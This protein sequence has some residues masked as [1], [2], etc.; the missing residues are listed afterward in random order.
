MARRTAVAQSVILGAD[1]DLSTRAMQ[2]LRASRRWA[3]PSRLHVVDV[4]QP[5]THDTDGTRQLREA[6]TVSIWDAAVC[7]FA[8]SARMVISSAETRR[9]P[10]LLAS[11]GEVDAG[12]V[13]AGSLRT[14]KLFDHRACPSARSRA[15]QATLAGRR[16]RPANRGGLTDVSHGRISAKR[17]PP[18]RRVGLPRR[19]PSPLPGAVTWLRPFV[20]LTCLAVRPE[21]PKAADGGSAPYGDGGGEGGEGGRGTRSRPSSMRAIA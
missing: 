21:G 6:G 15:T 2:R 9:R 4:V 13:P 18:R 10:V 1:E 19:R 8:S 12:R 16:Q 20:G 14:I 5:P 17:S 3:A 11:A 7:R